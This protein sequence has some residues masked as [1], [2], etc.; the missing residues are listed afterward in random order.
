MNRMKVVRAEKRVTQFEL[1]NKTGINATKISFVENGLIEATQEE[2]TKLA[3]AL[4]VTVD[5]VFPR[6]E[7]LVAGGKKT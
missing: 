5:E 2:K 7:R 6:A 4:G 3:G 1:R